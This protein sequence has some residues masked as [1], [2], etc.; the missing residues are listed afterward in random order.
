MS[1]PILKN[2]LIIS[3][4][5]K[6]AFDKIQPPFM[7]KLLRKWGIDEK[8]LKLIQDI[9]KKILQLTAY[10]GSIKVA[11][12]VK[13]LPA[14]WETLVWSESGRSPEEG[15]GNP[16]QCSCLENPMARGIWQATVHGVKKSWTWLSTLSPFNGMLGFPGGSRGKESTCQWR[17]GFN[18]WVRKIPWRRKCNPLQYSYLEN[19]MDRR[20]W[21]ATPCGVTVSQT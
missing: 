11:Q 3:I 20:A 19:P 12:I 1:F 15:N 14:M 8:F 13:N 17:R 4:D 9:Y 10:L 16:F 18:P 5:T 6:K 7:R 21:W 2:H